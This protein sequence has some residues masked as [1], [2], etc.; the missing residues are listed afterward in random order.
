M[1]GE[2]ATDIPDKIRVDRFNRG[3]N[4][5]G[6]RAYNE[7][8]V[9]TLVR[10]HRALT[11]TE[12]ARMTGLSLQTVSVIMRQLEADGLLQRG[13]PIRVRGKVG[14]P[15]V[16][17]SLVPDGALFFGLKVGRRSSDL[18]LI[19]FLGH[20]IA[21]VHKTYRYPLPDDIVRFA[22][23]AM[24]EITLDLSKARRSRIAGLGIGLPFYLWNWADAI[25]APANAMDAWR[26][27][28]IRAEIAARCEFPVYLRN[29]ASAACGGEL[30][31]G[32]DTTTRHFLY[33]YIGYFIGG[34]VVLN[35]SLYTGPS[36]N[37]GALGPMPV[38]SKTKANCQLI[39]VASIASLE[40]ALEAAG[41]TANR[42]W[43]T[44]DHWEIDE[45]LLDQWID[46]VGR[47]IA[48]AILSASSV[49]DFEAAVV[50]GW[51]PIPVRAAIVEAIRKYLPTLNFTGI[52]A[53][54]IKQGTVGYNAR[55][56]GAASL[57]LSLRFL[58]D[59]NASLAEH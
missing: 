17:M 24:E 58:V 45:R 57:P 34:G 56:I 10:R 28:D 54:E 33:F 38:P 43:E 31:F 22:Q 11:K 32:L 49:I 16:P 3:S 6:L 42:L 55:A 29:D 23:K 25:G 5:R 41:G 59:Q 4:Q 36:G 26:D 39:D 37:A 14:Q 13:Q 7:R 44:P 2:G 51:L 30:V 21:S 20:V 46:E 47:G 18:V 1:S 48:H 9:L 19:D 35:G 15:S 50:D 52:E 12:I 27:A 53:P 8:L 40:R